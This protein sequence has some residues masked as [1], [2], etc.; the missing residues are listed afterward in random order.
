MSNTQILNPGEYAFQ[1]V[2]VVRERYQGGERLPSCNV[3]KLELDV[4]D[5]EGNHAT[6][7]HRLYIHERTA[8]LFFE[9]F[10]GIGQYRRG[11][12]FKIDWFSVI[13]SAGRCMIVT[14]E[15]NGENYNAVDRILEPEQQPEPSYSVLTPENAVR[16]LEMFG[17]QNVSQWKTSD[18]MKLVHRIRDN[19]GSIPARIC[20]KTYMPHVNACRG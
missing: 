19:G 14:R 17:F 2:N 12:P 10:T 15:R 18:V 4:Y 8:G 11:E 5:Q 16:V 20:P 7:Y 6:V 3:A 9:F 1:V 13:G